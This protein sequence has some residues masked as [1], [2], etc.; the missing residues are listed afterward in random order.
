PKK[1]G[2]WFKADIDKLLLYGRFKRL[3]GVQSNEVSELD[4]KIKEADLREKEGKADKVERENS[5]ADGLLIERSNVYRELVARMIQ[6]KK[7][8]KTD[9]KVKSAD[10]IFLVGGDIEKEK[11]LQK[12]LDIG[13]DRRL[14][15]Y[16]KPFKF[17]VSMSE[18]EKEITA[19]EEEETSIE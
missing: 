9:N 5:K 11:E 7:D 1:N 8:E 13:T 14:N 4:R 6:L 19:I 10:I 15:R 16:A 3:A 2:V 18:M 12:Y 17:A